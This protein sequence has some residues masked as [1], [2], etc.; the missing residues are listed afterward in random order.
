MESVFR[1]FRN[2]GKHAIFILLACFSLVIS[3]F[4]ACWCPHHEIRPEK[5][6]FSCHSTSHD[7]G[8][9]ESNDNGTRLESSCPC[10]RDSSPIVLNKS[11]RKKTDDQRHPVE[12]F[13][14]PVFESA[15][16]FVPNNSIAKITRPFFQGDVHG[17]S[18]P[19]R[20]PP[21]L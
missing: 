7:T 13:D 11:D 8:V 4:G 15:V 1:T 17:L 18:A 20:A 12:P 2:K 16:H 10:T 9:A 3:S 14:L 5:A 19:S 6:E 21:R